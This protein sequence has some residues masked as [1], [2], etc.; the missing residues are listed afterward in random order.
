MKKL[1]IAVL[2][3][4]TVAGCS[5]SPDTEMANRLLELEKANKE[6][7]EQRI[8]EQQE[9]LEETLDVTPDWYLSP[10]GAD[11]TG[12]YGVGYAQSK[13]IGHGK[14]AARLQAEFD[15]AKM[16]R[17]ELSGSERAFERGGNEGN[18]QTQTT[19]LVDKIVDSV[20]VVG[21]TVVEQ[22]L[23]PVNGVYE[24]YV[25]L[26]LP[27]DEFNRV[28]I[29]ERE[30]SFDKTVQTQFDDLERRLKERRAEKEAAEQAVFNREQEALRN[31]AD[32]INEANKAKA[33]PDKSI[34]FEHPVQTLLKG[35]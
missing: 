10:P 27:Y 17:Q 13:N 21:Y 32:I 30:K 15:L 28:L 12:F 23:I 29:S 4:T 16:Y 3:A 8:A 25:L 18:V 1:I 9:K 5:S 7:R 14:K 6:M 2:V 26:K 35:N 33:E 24:A 19:F 34:K 22:K 11:S 20:P 31:R